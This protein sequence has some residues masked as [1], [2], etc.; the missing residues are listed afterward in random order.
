MVSKAREDLPEPD[1]PVMTMSLSRGRSTSTLARLWVRAPRTRMVSR[2]MDDLELDRTGK[3]TPRRRPG[4]KHEQT[5]N[6]G[7]KR[8][9]EALYMGAAERVFQPAGRARGAGKA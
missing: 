3:C 1:R 6:Q 7:G 4:A 2:A 9:I 8:R 5:G